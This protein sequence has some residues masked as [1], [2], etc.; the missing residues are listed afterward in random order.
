MKKIISLAV[1]VIITGGGFFAYKYFSGDAPK[2]LELTT[3]TTVAGNTG[4]NGKY[5]IL[6]N[7][8]TQAG[9]RIDEKFGPLA[10]T[11][12]VRTTAITGGTTVT[13]TTVSNVKMTVDMTKLKS[14][15]EQ[16]PG[17][18]PL[19]NRLKFM[20]T[21]GLETTRFPTAS[22]EAVSVSLPAAPAKGAKIT[23]NAAGNLT[24][25]GVTKAIT[26][27]LN[28]IWNGSVIDIQ[29]E[30]EVALADYGMTPPSL[31]FVD[32]GGKGSLEFKLTLTKA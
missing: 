30:A 13:G 31:G 23:V 5:T 25:H 15:D 3:R 2:K 16:P 12:V 24:L 1:L 9:F 7:A 27:A 14:I 22:F 17:G 21:G 28:A 10:H 20:Q 32:V 8:D 11:A 6:A 26:I 29:G 18:L 19:E 4:P